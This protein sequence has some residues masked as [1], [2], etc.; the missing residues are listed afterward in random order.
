MVGPATMTINTLSR[1]DTSAD[2]ALRY[3]SGIASYANSFATP[4]GW[5][6]GEPLWLDLGEVHDVAEVW[7][8]GSRA[9]GLWRAP[10]RLDIGA[11]ARAGTNTLEIKVANRWVNRL[12]GDAQ[13]GA[14]A[15]T[16]ASGPGYAPD[17]PLRP[18]GM[19]GPVRVL[20]AE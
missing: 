3:F 7:V 18:S 13:P 10:Y 6:A 2:P 1:C 9:G 11:L 5:S 19:A 17:A 14:V 20:V 15:G 12:V 8:N 16:F 4:A